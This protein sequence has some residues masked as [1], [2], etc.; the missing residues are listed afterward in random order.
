MPVRGLNADK[1]LALETKKWRLYLRTSYLRCTWQVHEQQEMR[2]RKTEGHPDGS[3]S[4][5]TQ[6]SWQ[7]HTRGPVPSKG[8]ANAAT[9]GSPCLCTLTGRR[10]SAQTRRRWCRWQWGRPQPPRG[11]S[12]PGAAPG[13]CSQPCPGSPGTVGAQHTAW[14]GVAVQGHQCV[15]SNTAAVMALI[16]SPAGQL[17]SKHAWVPCACKKPGCS[18]R[19]SRSTNSSRKADL[20]VQT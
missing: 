4:T 13:S 18:M 3:S 20:P 17:G 16:A 5:N 2:H 7:Q 9:Q 14:K 6:R 12:P 19:G 15:H 1:A 10:G 8:L 11:P